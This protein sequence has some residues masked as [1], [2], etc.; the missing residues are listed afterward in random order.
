MGRRIFWALAIVGATAA[1]APALA[2]SG[3][4]AATKAYLSADLRLA[5]TAASHIAIGRAAIDG[6]LGHVRSACPRAAA[7]SPQD[8]ESTELSNEVIGAMVTSAIRRDLP[9]IQAFVRATSSLRW[10]SRPLTTAVHEYVTKVRQ[11]S[12]LAQPDLCA[13]VRAWAV[14]G[15]R[16][17]PASTRAFAPKFMDSWVALGEIPAGMARYE[18]AQVRASARQAERSES[19]LSEFEVHEVETWGTIMNALALSP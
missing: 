1:P 12:T 13:D 11:L 17:L 6:V 5:Q 2:A 15:F 16:S 7:E 14:S 19:Q 18:T 9:S 3:D 4:A 8:P 10:S